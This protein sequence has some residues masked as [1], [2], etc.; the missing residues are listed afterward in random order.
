MVDQENLEV[1]PQFCEA[2]ERDF[3][4]AKFRCKKLVVLPV[5][6]AFLL[7]AAAASMAQR[8]KPSGDP[9]EATF[10]GGADDKITSDD[11]NSYKDGVD[12][13][14]AH[15]H[16]SGN[17]IIDPDGNAKKKDPNPRFL[18]LIL[19]N[20]VA[21]YQGDPGDPRFFDGT[22]VIGGEDYEGYFMSINATGLDCGG[23]GRHHASSRYG[24]GRLPGS[25]GGRELRSVGR[26]ERLEAAMR[27]CLGWNGRN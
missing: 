15:F 5:L 6:T 4:H 18:K 24:G 3:D 2:N 27:T 12:G 9:F 19:T 1:L 13:V 8:G 11:G 20:L 17:F 16:N 26:E 10:V 14:V 22:S 7:T 21:V 23:G 25:I